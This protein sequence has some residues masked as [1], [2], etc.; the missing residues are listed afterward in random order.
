LNRARIMA[1]P[2]VAVDPGVIGKTGYDLVS[3]QALRQEVARWA[4]AL[5]LDETAADLLTQ[6]E[7]CFDHPNTQTLARQIARAYGR[8]LGFL[9]LMLKRADPEN[10]AAR[11]EWSAAH[12]QF[13]QSITAVIVGGGRLAG[14][15]GRYALPAA[16]EVLTQH[17]LAEV[18]ITRSLYPAYLP[19]VGL[20]R[21]A[22]PQTP[23]MLLFDFGH[24]TIKRAVAQYNQDQ[25]SALHILLAVPTVCRDL[26]VTERSM[27]LVQ[28]QWQQMLGLIEDTWRQIKPEWGHILNL[29][30]SLACYLF[31]GHP[32][33]HDRGCY[34]SLQILSPHLETFM[35]H[36]IT[37]RLHAAVHIGLAH[38]GTAAALVYAGQTHSVV[39]TLGTA[40]G[41]GF[42]PPAENYRPLAPEF[43]V[44]EHIPL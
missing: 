26:S 16:Q 40:I 36:Q 34:D 25:L 23:A 7:H 38:D 22:R 5:K 20:A 24:T 37:D 21:T 42:P 44:E 6:F 15:F 12:W 31:E 10:R 41:N 30:I 35:Q 29:G 17:G 3:T 28:E 33:P 2:G 43:Q 18:T 19:L 32:S 11:P 14:Q 1:L 13:W 27:A 9:L 39:L 8:K 4:T